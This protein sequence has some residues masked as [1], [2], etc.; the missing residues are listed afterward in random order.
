MTTVVPSPS[1]IIFNATDAKLAMLNNI[2]TFVHQLPVHSHYRGTLIAIATNGIPTNH[3]VAITQLSPHYVTTAGAR[4]HHGDYQ[5]II[6]ELQSCYASGVTRVKLPTIETNQITSWIRNEC[7]TVS[8]SKDDAGW[9]YGS[10]TQLY[11]NYLLDLPTIIYQCMAELE[12]TLPSIYQQSMWQWR[13]AMMYGKCWT[14]AATRQCKWVTHT[15]EK[16]LDDRTMITNMFHFMKRVN[17]EYMMIHSVM[18]RAL[19]HH[20]DHIKDYINTLI[21]T[22]I[23]NYSTEIHHRPTPSITHSLQY[24]PRAWGAWVKVFN[25]IKIHHHARYMHTCYITRYIYLI[26]IFV[27][28]MHETVI[29]LN[30]VVYIA[31]EQDMQQQQRKGV[32]GRS[33]I[34]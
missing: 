25:T 8:G 28:M 13:Y 15:M 27:P 32:K 16:R 34:L 7:I 14:L 19:H 12:R 1:H 18:N 23:Y 4:Y 5:S 3:A 33:T 26:L 10:R 24:R 20:P 2:I 6:D 29:N 31:I 22:M 11:D 9:L 17:N 21:T 30:T